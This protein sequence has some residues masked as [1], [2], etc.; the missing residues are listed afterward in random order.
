M[1]KSKIMN[2]MQSSRNINKRTQNNI[3]IANIEN[4]DNIDSYKINKFP[5]IDKSM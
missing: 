1:G 3:D 4:I 2:K 5:Y